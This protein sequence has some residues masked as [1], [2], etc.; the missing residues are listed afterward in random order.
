MSNATEE[1]N[2]NLTDNRNDPVAAGDKPNR[3]PFFLVLFY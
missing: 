2:E 3:Q 1:E